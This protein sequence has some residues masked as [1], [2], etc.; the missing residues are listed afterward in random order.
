M[1]Q[2]EIINVNILLM[3]Y[4]CLQTKR[5]IILVRFGQM[6][7]TVLRDL[8]LCIMNICAYG[9][10]G[11]ARRRKVGGGGHKLFP[12]KVKSKKKKKKVTAA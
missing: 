10:S 9:D 3:Q 11:V 5:Q 6:K 7:L 8:C 12:R 4:S 2:N 1:F